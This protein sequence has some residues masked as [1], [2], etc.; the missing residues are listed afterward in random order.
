MGNISTFSEFDDFVKSARKYFRQHA[1][2]KQKEL[3]KV[4]NLYFDFLRSIGKSRKPEEWSNSKEEN[5]IKVLT[6]ATQTV[7]AMFYL[8]ESGFFDLALSLKRNFTE[9][10]LVAIAIGYDE[11]CY[12]DWKN[13]RDNFRD[14]HRISQRIL[15]LENVPQVEKQLIPELLRYWNESSQLHSHQITKK[16]IEEGLKIKKGNISL[17]SHIVKEEIQIKRLNT[18]RNMCLNVITILVGIFDYENLAK[19]NKSKFPE[20][21]SLIGKYNNFQRSELKLEPTI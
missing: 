9:L 15:G 3:G 10:L 14:P 17:G 5:L 13:D 20:A 19:K 8:S 12:I 18:L 11:Q 16:A 21:L 2:Q 4:F 7:F 6:K 1:K